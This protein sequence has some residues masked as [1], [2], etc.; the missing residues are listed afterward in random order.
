V[1]ATDFQ[2]ELLSRT[3]SKVLNLWEVKQHPDSA[4]LSQTISFYRRDALNSPG[5]P[6][7]S[8]FQS[9]PHQATE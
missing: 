4:D 9:H 2:P 8:F 3:A 5:L 6:F 1:K 7:H